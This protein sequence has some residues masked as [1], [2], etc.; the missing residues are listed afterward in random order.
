[1]DRNAQIAAKGPRRRPEHRTLEMTAVA[2]RLAARLRDRTLSPAA[3]D[4]REQRLALAGKL[5]RRG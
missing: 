3:M 4:H 5:H 2:A 1:M